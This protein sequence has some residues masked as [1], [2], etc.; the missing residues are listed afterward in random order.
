MADTNAHKSK[1]LKIV[2]ILIKNKNKKT[3]VGSNFILLQLLT[4]TE[5]NKTNFGILNG[6]YFCDRNKSFCF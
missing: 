5:Q 2:L 6:I 4:I 1:H 3:K